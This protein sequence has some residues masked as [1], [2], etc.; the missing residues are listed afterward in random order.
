MKLC[1]PLIFQAPS[2]VRGNLPHS[3]RDKKSVRVHYVFS[4]VH[5]S[6]R[7]LF[8]KEAKEV[9]GENISSLL[10]HLTASASA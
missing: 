2:P 6:R 9:E 7:N 3:S 1:L 5:S 10:H 8:P 4:D